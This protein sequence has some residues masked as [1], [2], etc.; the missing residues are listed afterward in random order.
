M[1][2]HLTKPDAILLETDQTLPT[3][4][5]VYKTAQGKVAVKVDYEIK[6]RNLKTG[7][8]E[9]AQVNIVRTGSVVNDERQWI[10]LNGYEL[11]WGSL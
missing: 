7:K 2:Q 8:K 11:L 6:L 9:K 10:S 5:F 3:L 1:P 4:L